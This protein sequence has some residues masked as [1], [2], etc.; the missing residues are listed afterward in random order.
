MVATLEQ[1]K[2][3]TDR[4]PGNSTRS[5]HKQNTQDAKPNIDKRILTQEVERVRDMIDQTDL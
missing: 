3:R 4:G 2:D 1:S 5:E